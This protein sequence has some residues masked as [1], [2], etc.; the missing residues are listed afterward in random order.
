MYKESIYINDFMLASGGKRFANYL[1]DTL[2]YYILIFLIGLIAGLLSEVFGIDGMLIWISEINPITEIFFNVSIMVIYYLF[3]ESLTQRSLGKFIT[4][5]KV[6]LIDGSKPEAGTIG[7]RTLCRIIPFEQFSF[8][9]G[10]ARGWHDS[11][12]KTFVIDI[13]KYNAEVYRLTALSEIGQEQDK[14]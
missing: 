1:V 6:V 8:L 5:T 11:F 2:A 9:G 14:Y 7:I 3:M 4:G 13:A 12:S 10:K